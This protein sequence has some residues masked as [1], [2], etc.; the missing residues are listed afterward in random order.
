MQGLAKLS[1]WLA[2]IQLARLC[3]VSETPLVTG[4][5]ELVRFLPDLESFISTSEAAAQLASWHRLG[6]GSAVAVEEE[7]DEDEVFDEATVISL[8]Q[9]SARLVRIEMMMDNFTNK[10]CKALLVHSQSLGS[11]HLAWDRELREKRL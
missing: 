1:G 5:A 11:L 9:T 7:N 3:F 8:I 2:L 6:L 10:I 4:F